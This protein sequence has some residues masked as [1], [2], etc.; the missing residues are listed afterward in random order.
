MPTRTVRPRVPTRDSATWLN[1]DYPPKRWLRVNFAK[2]PLGLSLG[3]LG[4]KWTPLILR[5]LGAYHVE[6]FNRLL[7]TIPGIPPKVLSTRLRELEE[8]GL[9]HK[10]EQSRKPILVR[11]DLTDRGRDLLPALMLI[12]AFESKYYGDVVHPG[13]PPMKV[14]EMYDR[15]AMELLERLL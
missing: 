9:I 14:H 1:P 2:C 6:R 15:D 11:W 4:R 10:V 5:D 7:E 13:R 3:V 12:T 8:A